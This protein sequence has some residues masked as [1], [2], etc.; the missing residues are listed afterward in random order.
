MNYKKE[1]QIY[2]SS[3]KWKE[4]RAEARLRSGNQC[5]FCGGP[6]DHVHHV[7][8]PKRYKDDH[9]DNL[10][11]ACEAC[12]GKLHGIKD[13][14]FFDEWI[15]DAISIRIE[16]DRIVVRMLF[17]P[18]PE[19]YRRPVTAS[20]EVKRLGNKWA[21]DLI[22]QFNGDIFTIGMSYEKDVFLDNNIFNGLF[23]DYSFNDFID[24]MFGERDVLENPAEI[25]K[26]FMEMFSV[27]PVLC[28]CKFHS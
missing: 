16:N 5:E 18:L 9:L 25:S 12:H 21:Q 24:G 15:G 7:K 10:V 6:P 27:G 13:D 8:Y 11:V 4:L 17:T 20:Y 3:P 2:L 14:I 19:E 22:G 23:K 1:Y 26:A 28:P